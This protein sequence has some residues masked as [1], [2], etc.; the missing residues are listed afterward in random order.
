M[1]SR[2]LAAVAFGALIMRASFGFSGFIGWLLGNR[3]SVWLGMVSYGLYLIHPFVPHLYLYLLSASDLPVGVWSVYYIR[4]P[5]M[6][7]TLLGL[8]AASFYL[9]ERPI[10]SYRR[11][12]HSADTRTSRS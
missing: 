2:T 11:F 9:W 6:T 5:L 12:L 7:I 10:R 3:V 1:V 4:I 8:T